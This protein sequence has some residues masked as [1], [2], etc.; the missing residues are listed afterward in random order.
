MRLKLRW[1][2]CSSLPP[3]SIRRKGELETKNPGT[4]GARVEMF[5]TDRIAFSTFFRGCNLPGTSCPKSIHVCNN[6]TTPPGGGQPE[7]EPPRLSGSG[8]QG[9][10]FPPCVTLGFPTCGQTSQ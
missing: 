4:E 9:V 3:N 2:N 10:P 5:R 1:L 6:Y 7:K 8:Q